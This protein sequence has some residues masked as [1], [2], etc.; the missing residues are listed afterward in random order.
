MPAPISRVFAVI[1]DYTRTVADVNKDLLKLGRSDLNRY[2]ELT[3]ESTSVMRHQAAVVAAAAA[4]GAACTCLGAFGAKDS[5]A[6]PAADPR[7]NANEGIADVLKGAWDT[8]TSKAVTETGAKIGDGLSKAAPSWYGA[9]TTELEAKREL[10]K[11][12]LQENQGEKTENNRSGQ[13]LQ[14]Q[15]SSI[16]QVKSKG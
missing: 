15:L 1:S 14:E 12:L 8:V 13:K 6:P 7:Q 4:L 5:P 9:Q 10:T 3:N 16:L 11:M 2:G